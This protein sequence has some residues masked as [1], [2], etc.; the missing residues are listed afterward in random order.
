LLHTQ[1]G[2]GWLLSPFIANL[3]K[4]T[5]NVFGESKKSR[6]IIL[7]LFFLSIFGIERAF[8]LEDLSDLGFALLTGR[9]KVLSRTTLFRWMKKC[10]KS[11]IL[12]FYELTRPL[13][14]L[15]G[16][17]LRISIDEHVVARWTR[18]IK[19]AGTLHPTRGKAMKADK[20]FYIFDLETKRILG[21]KPKKGSANLANTALNMIKELFS[22]AKPKSIRMVLDAGGCKGSVIARFNNIKGLIYLI[23]AKRYP[24][25]VEQWKKVPEDEFIEYPD[26]GDP[27]NR[28]IHI[29]Q[30][31]TKI[32]GCRIPIRTILI[33]NKD[34]KNEK[35]RFYPIYTND[36]ATP[37]Y[38]MVIEY[39]GRQNHELCYRVLKHILNLDVL[40][41]SYP[42][43]PTAENVQ[44]RD[45]S[46][47]LI[48][49]IKA[50]AFNVVSDFK[51]SLDE[52]YHKMTIGT[53]VR[54]FIHR[55]ATIET[56]AD[57]IIVTFDHFKEQDALMD[58]CKT[59]NHNKLEI[60]WLENKVLRFEFE[61]LEEF[62]KRK[63]FLLNK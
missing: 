56:T 22:S 60:S 8:H 43:N 1:F 6:K 33:L 50:I 55:P 9:K 51:E 2:G 12:E 63:S 31:E 59:V 30:T 24:N 58:Y 36:E 5:E 27:E 21:L 54:K 17:K 29:A 39:R 34:E 53:I 3:L 46:V 62:K 38:D 28:T 61:S 52:K 16:K 48:G 14:N 42:L 32:K 4:K 26:P 25:L 15:T 19:L 10:P 44:F 57:E 35:D 7:T 23:R 11:A 45:K 40:P 47:M 18:K 49:W 37:A 13:E 41:K 20:L